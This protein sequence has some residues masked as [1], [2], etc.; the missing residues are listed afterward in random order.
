LANSASPTSPDEN[1]GEPQPVFYELY[2]WMVSGGGSALEAAF[3]VQGSVSTVVFFGAVPPHL[4][5]SGVGLPPVLMAIAG[6][7]TSATLLG[8]ITVLDAPDS[9][10]L[11]LVRNTPNAG[12]VNCGEPQ[13][14]YNFACTPFVAR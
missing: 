11:T 5:L 3:D 7:P 2:L 9:L 10:R 1:T 8:T 12:V 13:A 4:S 14:L 6:C